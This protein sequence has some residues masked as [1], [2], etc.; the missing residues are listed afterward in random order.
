MYVDLYVISDSL[1]ISTAFSLCN[2][3]SSIEKYFLLN[4]NTVTMSAFG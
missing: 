2:V 4:N 1:V 3:T